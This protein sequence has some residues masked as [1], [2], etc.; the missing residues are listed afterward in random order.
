MDVIKHNKA[1]N[2][3]ESSLGSTLEGATDLGGALKDALSSYRRDSE[4]YV[5]ELVPLISDTKV[6]DPEKDLMPEVLK[7]YPGAKLIR[8]IPVP[9]RPGPTKSQIATENKY[10]K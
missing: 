10:L 7:K 4:G 6:T 1:L 2:L 3:L 9:D 8:Y 5:L